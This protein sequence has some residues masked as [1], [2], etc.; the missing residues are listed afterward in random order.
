MEGFRVGGGGWVQGR[1]VVDGFGV[2]GGGVDGFKMGRRWMGSWW[3]GGGW[4]SGQGLDGFRVGGGW[5]G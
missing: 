3:G 2:G 1:V 4:V 5:Q